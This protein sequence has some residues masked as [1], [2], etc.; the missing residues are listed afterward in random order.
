MRILE[1][2]WGGVDLVSPGRRVRPTAEPLRRRWM[3]WLSAEIRGARVLD[4]FAGTGALGLEALSRGAS[5]VDFVENGAEA[6]HALKANRTRLRATRQ[7]RLFKKEAFRFLEGVSGIRYDLT[8]ADPPYT[9]SLAEALV[10]RW[11][12]SPFSIIL[13]VEHSREVI[14]PGKGSRRVHE[15]TAVTTYRTASEK[16]D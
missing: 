14:L 4:L 2:T 6:L 1:G 7:S 10:E 13:S 3:E 11:H 8:F 16:E 12:R 9:S 5:S 15:D